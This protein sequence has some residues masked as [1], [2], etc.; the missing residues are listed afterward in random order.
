MRRVVSSPA[1]TVE[2]YL[3]ALEPGRRDLLARVRALVVDNLPEGYVETMAWG[4]PCY[5]VPLERFPGTYNGEP[6]G[7]V[8]FAA[9][10][11]HCSL[12]LMWLH[13][14]SEAEREFRE[15]WAAG[16][17]TLD[18]GRSC[19]R[20]RRLEDLD[21]DLLGRAIASQPVDEH[22]ASYQRIRGATRAG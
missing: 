5:V 7:Y 2:E 17:R 1:R 3:D 20:F 19:L 12:Y 11:R 15:Q 14:G 9:Q 16:G 18:M 13:A 4:M 8:A 22:L 21:L 10:K 6:L